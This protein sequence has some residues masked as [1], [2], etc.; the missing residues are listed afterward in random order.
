MSRR[1]SPEIARETV[2]MNEN[3][4]VTEMAEK[5]KKGTVT[6]GEMAEVAGAV[7]VIIGS[8]KAGE[9][10]GTNV[11]PGAHLAA[12]L[13]H[14]PEDVLLLLGAVLVALAHDPTRVRAPGVAPPAAAKL[15]IH[16][17]DPLAAR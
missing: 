2:I 17:H 11:V 13:V 10:A 3:E 4:N 14:D 6:A 9:M 16:S 5:T 15:L 7:Q 1:R 12:P 8:L